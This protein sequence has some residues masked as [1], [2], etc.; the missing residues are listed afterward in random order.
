MSQ[1]I[2]G[3]VETST[4]LG[5]VRTGTGAVEIISCSRSSLAPAMRGLLDTLHAIARLAGARLEES[6]GYPGW[7]PD[8]ASPA[9]AVAQAAYRKLFG[10]RARVTAVH[11]GLECGLIGEKVPGLDMV[12]FGPQ[13]RGVHAPGEKVHLPSV[14]RFWALLAATLDDLSTVGRSQPRLAAKQGDAATG[15][16]RNIPASPHAGPP[17]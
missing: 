17:A 1:D 14:T 10:E 5:V 8:M 7:K 16:H 13:L 15:G 11:A 12:S 4:N 3:L 9:L 2:P 6:T